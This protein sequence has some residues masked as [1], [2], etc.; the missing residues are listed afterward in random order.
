YCAGAGRVEYEDVRAIVVDCASSKVFSLVDAI[1]EKDEKALIKIYSDML[2]TKEDPARI[3]SLLEQQFL[4]LLETD[5]LV[6]GTASLQRMEEVIGPEWMVRKQRR[7][8][9]RI[10]KEDINNVLRQANRYDLL[11]KSGKMKADDALVALLL[12]AVRRK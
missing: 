4:K 3:I 2:M 8:L 7:L 6:S 1:V 12:S 11:I 5:S 10:K 9:S